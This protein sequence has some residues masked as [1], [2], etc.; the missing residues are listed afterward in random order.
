MN[1]FEAFISEL[2]NLSTLLDEGETLLHTRRV[3]N[4]TPPLG[5]YHRRQPKKAFHGIRVAV[6]G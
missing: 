5:A 4:A 6:L 3:A 2:M 1:F